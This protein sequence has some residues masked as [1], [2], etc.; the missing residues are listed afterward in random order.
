MHL[1]RRS[2]LL[3]GISLPT[4]PSC[5]A[6]VRQ[7][8]ARLIDRA[9]ASNAAEH[10]ISA[11]AVVILRGGEAVYRQYSGHTASDGSA[12]VDQDS[13]FQIYSVSKLFA[14]VL[15]LQL[16][17]QGSVDLDAPASRYVDGLPPT[18]RATLVAQF[19][20]HVSGV[21]EYYDATD[22][23][24]PFLPS[25][26]AVFEH[27]ADRPMVDPPGTRTRY[28]GT[29][30][31]V[32]E[33]ILESVTGNSYSD[34]VR[35]R[36]M[37]PIGLRNTWLGPDGVPRNRL[38][39][40]YHGKDGRLVPDLPIAWPAYSIAHGN[41][42]STADDVAAFLSAVAKGQF[43][44]REVLMR[45]W[46]PYT[47]PNGNNGYFA[48]GWEYGESGAWREVGH[49][50]GAKVRVRIVFRDGLT[51]PVVIVYL[52]NG[53]RDNVWSRTLVE[54]VQQIVLSQ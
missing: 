20:N 37:A 53:S 52:T 17:E 46:K 41:L 48:S 2:I 12:L 21:P 34:L 19:L 36:I 22:L 47:F 23:S 32:I 8:R 6:D 10:G 26:R 13:V 27:L 51:Q 1:S 30:F 45:R 11:Q 44:S 14:T 7:L 43:V 39:A 50:G 18:W 24:Q 38:V 16:A 31:L 15:L 25:L 40:D 28:T 49:D 42:Y 35:D 4:L 3:A 5:A 33:A 54:S 29:N 9:I